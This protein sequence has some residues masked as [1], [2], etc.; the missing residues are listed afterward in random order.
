MDPT[1]SRFDGD[2]SVVNQELN[3]GIA[4]DAA[5]RK[6]GV[7][8]QMNVDKNGL[9]FLPP[10]LTKAGKPVFDSVCDDIRKPSD[11]HCLSHL[12]FNANDSSSSSSIL[13]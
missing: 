12:C 6:C 11:D 3:D 9:E 5:V 7:P 2:D 1:G 8:N 13:L 4:Q 10:S